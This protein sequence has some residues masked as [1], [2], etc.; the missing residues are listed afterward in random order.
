MLLHL[1][2]FAQKDTYEFSRLDITNGLSDNQVNCIYKDEKGFMWFGTTSGLNRY[3]GS[4]FKIFK[5]DNNNPNSL[6]ENHVMRIDGGPDH[7]MWVF[8][9][10][11]ISVYNPETEKMNNNIAAETKRYN[12]PNAQINQIKKDFQG[13]YWFGTDR[14]GLYYY[15]PVAKTTTFYSTLS[16]SPAVLHSDHISSIVPSPKKTVWLLYDD[17]VIEELNPN[18]QKGCAHLHRLCRSYWVNSACLHHAD[19]PY[20][21]PVDLLLRCTYRCI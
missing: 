8:T 10:N 6:A 11:S 18:Q 19:R 2:L 20:A 12:I 21:K 3:D 9:H 16:N 14:A 7:K 17:G 15:N 5:R 1:R 13:N 4:K